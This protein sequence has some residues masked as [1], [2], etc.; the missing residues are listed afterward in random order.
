MKENIAISGAGIVSP[1]GIGKADFFASLKEGKSGIKSVTGF[2]TKLD[3]EFFGGEIVDFGAPVY[4]GNKGIRHLNRSSKMLMVAGQLALMDSMVRIRTK[5]FPHYN[6]IMPN[7]LTLQLV[8]V[9][10]SHKEGIIIGSTLGIL[11]SSREFFGE[12]CKNGWRGVNP[13]EFP[14][15]VVN[16]AAGYLAIKEK[17][18]GVN[19]TLASGQASST[20]ALGMA[21]HYL[22]EDEANII[23]S[24][25]T[26]ELGPAAY[27]LFKKARLLCDKPLDY[28][29][30]GADR[31][32]IMLGEGSAVFILEKESYARE[33]G[34]EIHGRIEGYGAS[35]DPKSSQ[36]SYDSEARSAKEAI[37]LALEDAEVKPEDI[38]F[39]S[40]GLCG[41]PEG[42]LMELKA[43]REVLGP[44]QLVI[45]VKSL[46]GET[47]DCG[48]AFQLAAALYL[49]ENKFFAEKSTLSQGIRQK[50]FSPRRALITSFGF[51]GNNSALVVSR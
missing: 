44:D 29:P 24:G 39:V 34:A 9:T 51:N 28:N 46:I 48:G 45:A 7:S 5:A 26:F 17:A 36:Y 11:D 18:Q 49:F 33:T 47:Y 22:L 1:I 15:T 6:F 12:Y 25:G 43:I 35:F 14:N 31:S 50:V 21:K 38:D 42:D 27:I 16:V 30:T 4:L 41:H 37:Q 3:E 13:M 10:S 8:S 32:G 23:F 40:S 2:K 20:D 19:L